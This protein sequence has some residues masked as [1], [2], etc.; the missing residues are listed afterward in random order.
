MLKLCLHLSVKVMCTCTMSNK[1]SGRCDIMCL[2]HNRLA[3]YVDQWQSE[4]EERL[5]GFISWLYEKQPDFQA[6]FNPG[7]C[8]LANEWPSFLDSWASHTLSCHETSEPTVLLFIAEDCF[9]RAHLHTFR[10][11]HEWSIII[12]IIMSETVYGHIGWLLL[13]ITACISLSSLYAWLSVKRNCLT[14][15]PTV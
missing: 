4:A 14:V 10:V 7:A 2:C 9:Q 8:H 11:W 6:I 13:M 5:L 1:H 12:I 3:V 15:L